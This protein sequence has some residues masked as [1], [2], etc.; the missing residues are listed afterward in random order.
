MPMIA[1]VIE[2][3]PKCLQRQCNTFCIYK[4]NTSISK[5]I[6]T[7][8]RKYRQPLVIFFCFCPIS[9]HFVNWMRIA[10]HVRKRT[11]Y[12]L[13]IWSHFTDIVWLL[14]HCHSFVQFSGNFLFFFSKCYWKGH[15]KQT[16]FMCSR[17][18]ICVFVCMFVWLCFRLHEHA[19]GSCPP[20]RS[21]QL[22]IQSYS[23][24]LIDKHRWLSFSF[25][26]NVQ[27]FEHIYMQRR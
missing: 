10:K 4:Y 3:F 2:W 1:L 8:F 23:M 25:L 13:Q 14:L 5:L 11:Y 15:I 26:L 19:D 9:V 7:H 17:Y 6:H 24:W 22:Y 21:H 16:D 12:Y 27:C 18:F 20:T